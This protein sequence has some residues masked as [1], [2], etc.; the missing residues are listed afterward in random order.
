MSRRTLTAALSVVFLAGCGGSD[1]PEPEGQAP[2]AS[3]AQAAPATPAP[4]TGPTTSL[5]AADIP[6]QDLPSIVVYKTPTCGCCNGWIEHLREAGFEVEARDV[7]D[8]MSVKLDV[9]VPTDLSSCHTALVDGYV[10][11]G[12]VPA[13][14]VKKLV[15]ERPDVAGITVPGMPVGSPGMEGPN[16]RP[17]TVEAFTADGSHTTYAEVDPR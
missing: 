10:V 9:G 7:R 11:E 12:H 4:D 3:V 15:A 13:D 14:V 5:A 17:Y 1:A 16:A 8:L 2:S 6:D